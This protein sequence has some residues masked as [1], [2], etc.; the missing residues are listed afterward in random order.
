MATGKD[1]R[2]TS[3]SSY[4]TEDL[5]C[6]VE[7][8]KEVKDEKG[9]KIGTKGFQ[10]YFETDFTYGQATYELGKRGYAQCWVKVK[11]LS[12]TKT[13]VK[14]KKRVI[15]LMN[16]ERENPVRY[17]ATFSKEFVKKLNK[18]PEGIKKNDRRSKAIEAA[19]M[20]MVDELLRQRER[21]TLVFRETKVEKRNTEH[22]V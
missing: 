13:T 19:L 16:I 8:I 7:K 15:D 9:E 17:E 1:K 20:P 3:V 2:D 6:M 4:S 11:D 12:E 18:L 21:G 5:L 14:E 10:D 22:E